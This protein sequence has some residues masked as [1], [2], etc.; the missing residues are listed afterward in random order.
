MKKITHF[1]NKFILL[2]IL[3]LP[4]IIHADGLIMVPEIDRDF[5]KE[6]N[7][8]AFINYE[9]GFEKMIISVGTEGENKEGQVWLFPVP[10]KPEGVVIDIIDS[11]PEL[12]GDDVLD[13]AKIQLEDSQEFFLEY[14]FSYFIFPAL[15]NETLGVKSSYSDSYGVLMPFEIVDFGNEDIEIHEHIEKEGIIS[16]IITAKT[17]KGLDVYLKDKGIN[18]KEKSIPVLDN[19]I[20]KDYSFVVSWINP[21][22]Q[23]TSNQVGLFVTFPT[24]KMYFPLLPTSVYESEIVPATIRVIGYVTPE[25]FDNIKNY[26]KISYYKDD[27]SYLEA[28]AGFFYKGGRDIKYTKIEIESPSKYLT[29]DLWIK[30]KT[31]LKVSLFSFIG[32]HPF[33]SL[34]LIMLISAVL[35]G[36]ILSF[37]FFKGMKR[38]RLK[39]ILISLFN[40]LTA[41]GL[42]IKLA[43]TKTKEDKKDIET[44]GVL[45]EL[46]EKGYLWRRKIS[47]FSLF[48]ATFIFPFFLV[49]SLTMLFNSLSNPS[50]YPPGQSLFFL[51]SNLPFVVSLVAFLLL[52]RIKIKDTNLFKAI[53]EKGYSSWT[54]LPKDK[55][56]IYFFFASHLL[57]VW[58]VVGVLFCLLSIV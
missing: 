6:T 27:Y 16:E 30:N 15:L 51:A 1:F 33:L 54:F 23:K 24:D 20:G 31:P 10:S 43:F 8:Q 35:S 46:K 37:I 4:S 38:R 2:S 14:N 55:Q 56:K 29:D 25:I 50:Y 21:D 9:N 41:L 17:A 3:L 39:T 40:L 58:L 57:Y 49:T 32:E 18:L 12:S 36:L 48:L 22:E 52:K 42:I 26:T 34:F 11:L 44:E 53:K 5:S 19:Y 47:I 45:M 7:Q 13:K 28:E